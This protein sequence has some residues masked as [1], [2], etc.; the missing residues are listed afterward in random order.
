MILIVGA[1]GKLGNEVTRR[2]LAEG[3][4]VRAMSRVPAR[5]EG[6]RQLGAEIVAGDLTDRAS[7][8]RA[9]DGVTN[10][11]AAAH[12]FLG[13]GSNT[14][15][16]VDDAG[17][18][19]L[20]DAARSAGVRHFVFTSACFGSDDPVDF[21]RVKHAIEQYLRA[22][23]LPYTVLRPGAF[24]EDHAERIGGP[25]LKGKRTV[26]FGEGKAPANFVAVRDVAEIA[27][28][29]LRQQPRND[30]VW[31]GGPQN[32]S[33][34]DVAGTYAR[35]SG[36]S[37]QVAHVP[38]WFLRAVRGTVGRAFPVVG[39][40]I[41]AGIFTDSGVQTIDMTATLQ[42]YPVRLTSLEEFIRARHPEVVK[43]TSV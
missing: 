23:G 19:G 39:R 16:R 10:V 28:M 4:R 12:S 13:T 37:I 3:E 38:L 31:I 26:L 33:A 17:N 30:V 8:R 41:D 6:L 2:L 27:V 18:R 14:M 9:C 32:L 24:M 35:V 1:S 15:S 29:V 25:I 5:I 11:L 20:V 36:R 43:R 40:V 34:V 42:R 21:F 22:S 7:L